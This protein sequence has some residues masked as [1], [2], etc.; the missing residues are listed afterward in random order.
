MDARTVAPKSFSL[1][2][3]FDGPTIYVSSP[4]RSKSSIY[5]I[6][7]I[8]TLLASLVEWRFPF[9]FWALFFLRSIHSIQLSFHPV[10]S[11]CLMGKVGVLIASGSWPFLLNGSTR[12]NRRSNYTIFLWFISIHKEGTPFP[13]KGNLTVKK[14]KKGTKVH[15]VM[16]N[17]LFI[18]RFFFSIRLAKGS[19]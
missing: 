10:S 2:E 5:F 14:K 18:Y 12:K 1:V 3:S 9:L 17:C 11:Q 7:E 16:L 6:F 4:S 13:L 15:Y 19:D 8:F